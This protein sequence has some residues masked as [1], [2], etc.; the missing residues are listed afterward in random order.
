LRKKF[1][2]WIGGDLGIVL[3][4]KKMTGAIEGFWRGDM[5]DRLDDCFEAKGNAFGGLWSRD[6]L[7][8]KLEGCFGV[9]KI[10]FN[11]GKMHLSK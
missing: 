6:Y 1:K 9:L 11:I 7:E 2:V 4:P 5:E 8:G 10:E 3:R